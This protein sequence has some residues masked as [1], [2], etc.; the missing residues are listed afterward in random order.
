MAE[1]GAPASSRNAKK[2]VKKIVLFMRSQCI[3]LPEMI[4]DRAPPP[5]NADKLW[6]IVTKDVRKLKN[7]EIV[8][9]KSAPGA[10]KSVK[11][12][13]KT[14]AAVPAILPPGPMSSK[15]SASNGKTDR[16]TD[17]K[18][19]KGEM[20]IEGRLDLHGNTAVAARKKLLAYVIKSHG[21]GKRC[22]LLVTGK[23]LS[24]SQTSE[25]YESGKGIIRREFRL[26]L[27]DKSVNAL[28]LLVTEAQPKHGGS[29]AF[30]I[31]LR[32]NRL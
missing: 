20:E 26:W 7:P 8:P 4:K 28:I 17:E 6:E 15:Q 27:E 5:E 13:V 9:V 16:K 30:Y 14:P 24:G 21:Q 2:P 25:W 32:K 23:G 31:Y 12:T 29:G 1:A 19:R 11:K 18:I 22:V 10:K 3:M